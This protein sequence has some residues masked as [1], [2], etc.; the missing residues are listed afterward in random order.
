M[1]SIS[2]APQLPQG[3]GRRTGDNIWDRHV[4]VDGIREHPIVRHLA[5]PVLWIR[6]ICIELTGQY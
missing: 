2:P 5:V 6:C 4:R 1:L 3:D